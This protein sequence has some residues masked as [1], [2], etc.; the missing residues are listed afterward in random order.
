MSFSS[1]FF[2]S[3]RR[4]LVWRSFNFS[5]RKRKEK[6]NEKLIID[7][8]KKVSLHSNVAEYPEQLESI[9]LNQRFVTRLRT[10]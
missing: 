6:E 8:E 4:L 3:S 1:L 7:Q 2:F 5:A 9:W 10:H